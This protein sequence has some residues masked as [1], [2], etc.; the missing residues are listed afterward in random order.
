[1]KQVPSPDFQNLDD[2]WQSY[3]AL[4]YSKKKTIFGA[5]PGI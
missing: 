2:F 1:M 3:K 5:I 4:V